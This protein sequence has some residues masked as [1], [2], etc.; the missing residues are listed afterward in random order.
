M[1]AGEESIVNKK[2]EDLGKLVFKGHLLLHV[3]G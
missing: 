2:Y 1:T 3:L